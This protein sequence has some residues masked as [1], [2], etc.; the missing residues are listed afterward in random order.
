[1]RSSVPGGPYPGNLPESSSEL[2]RLMADGDAPASAE[3][4]V[5]G[6][7]PFRLLEEAR[8]GIGSLPLHEAAERYP[9]EAW[10]VWSSSHPV[11]YTQWSTPSGDSQEFQQ[12]LK[13]FQRNA[14]IVRKHNAKHSKEPDK[15]LGLINGADKG[16]WNEMKPGVPSGPYRGGIAE[17]YSKYKHMME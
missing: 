5:P 2:L 7:S 10:M 3:A 17:P 15:F 4:K 8:D 1:M 16:P 13:N 14:E 9:L 6:S 11:E 12:R